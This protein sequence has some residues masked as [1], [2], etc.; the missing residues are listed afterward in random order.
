LFG[1]LWWWKPWHSRH[2]TLV[3]RAP[4]V[5][6][7]P[8]A[9]PVPTPVITSVDP[10]AVEGAG[11]ASLTLSFSADCP[12]NVRD[13]NGRTLFAGTGAANSV[14]VLIGEA[15]LKVYLGAAS[16]VALTING[17]AAAIAAQF[18]R[19]DAARFNAGADGVLRRIPR[20][21]SKP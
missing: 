20:E 11:R 10:P 6:T 18:V 14:K 15:P 9:A 19:G 13:A 5:A 7:A 3:A 21:A 1:L 2:A 8:I 17:H 4:V 12:V 16:G